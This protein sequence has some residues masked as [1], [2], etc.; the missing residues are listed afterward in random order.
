[1]VVVNGV[2][3][4]VGDFVVTL[5]IEAVVTLISVVV[6][7]V[8]IVGTTIGPSP[9]APESKDGSNFLVISDNDFGSGW[10]GVPLTA[11]VVVGVDVCVTGVTF[12]MTLP[13]TLT[14][15]VFND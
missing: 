7:A 9:H 3:T 5:E 2:V 13:I 6:T 12:C 14:F 8:E 4:V 1:M 11:L 15:G 10:V